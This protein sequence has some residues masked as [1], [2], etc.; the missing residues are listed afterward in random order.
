MTFVVTENC[1]NLESLRS[2]ALGIIQT[3][4]RQID[5]HDAAIQDRDRQIHFKECCRHPS[6]C[7]GAVST[8]LSSGA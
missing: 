7:R 2:L 3:Q 4:R 5:A 6:H 1:I 8:T